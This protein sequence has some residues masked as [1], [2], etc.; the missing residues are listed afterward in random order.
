MNAEQSEQIKR[1]YDEKYDKPIVY[2]RSYLDSESLVEKMACLKF[3]Q[4]LWD[5]TWL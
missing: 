4:A 1:G 3:F 2:A 5:N